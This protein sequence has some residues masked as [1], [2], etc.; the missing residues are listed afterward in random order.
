MYFQKPGRT[1]DKSGRNSEYQEKISKIHM[2]TLIIVHVYEM[3]IS[4]IVYNR[5]GQHTARA[6]DLAR[7]AKISGPRR[8]FQLESTNAEQASLR[9]FIIKIYKYA[10]FLLVSKMCYLFY[11]NFST[12]LL[13]YI[14][15]SIFK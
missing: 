2:A 4:M 15:L 1:F 13:Y 8:A 10:L 5:G 12:H 3:Y 14:F 11:F 9:F 6:P 7:Q